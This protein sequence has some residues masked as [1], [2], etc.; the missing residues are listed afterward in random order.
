LALIKNSMATD[1]ARD[2]IV[3]DL[4]DVR[5]Q[6]EMLMDQARKRAD[7][8]IA[9][10]KVER[11]KIM[12]GAK[13][14]GRTEGYAKG[15]E[16]GRTAGTQQGHDAALKEQRTKLDAMQSSW[17]SELAIF[18]GL[19]EELLL[20]ARTSVLRLAL[21]I[22]EKLVKRTIEADPSVV[23]DQLR[24]AVELVIHPSRL[25]VAIHPDDREVLERATPGITA[26]FR[27]AQ[28]IDLIDDA[29]R[30]RGSCRVVAQRVQSGDR[31]NHASSDA[32]LEID[33]TIE[34]Q[35]ARIAAMLLPGE[36]AA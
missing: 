4:S 25:K 13:E 12:S 28:H 10:S 2:A 9:E 17:I 5:R 32:G 24:A 20:D 30:S 19:R 33:A 1:I 23:V 29:A 36:D 22:A 27:N 26:Q 7:A 6:G 11:D 21:A 16:E 8:T 31:D 15:L 14:I 34:S 35:L 3:F 18:N